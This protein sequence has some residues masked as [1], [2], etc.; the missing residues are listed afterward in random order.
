MKSVCKSISSRGKPNDKIYTPA[1]L[2]D[3]LLNMCD[4]KDGDR[5]LDCC[6]GEGAFYNKLPPFVIK[7]WCEIDKGKDFF[8]WNE[9]VDWVIGN[10]PYSV[11]T[12]WLEHTAKITDKFVYVF[13]SYNFT[14]TR[15]L[16]LLEKGFNITEIVLTKVDWWFSH[17]FVIKFEK[18]KDAII[19]AHPTIFCDI[20]NT[21][22]DRGRKGNSSNKC[23]PRV[24]KERE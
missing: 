22:C 18:N 12:K 10:P 6:M 23:C 5:V 21:R 11:W 20:C 9:K 2:V 4:F 14:E 1:P 15:I 8:E 16:S 13:G 3:I 24:K 19:K 17:T 7:E